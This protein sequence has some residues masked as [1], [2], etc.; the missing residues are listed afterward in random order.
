[1]PEDEVDSYYD[2]AVLR[3]PDKDEKGQELLPKLEKYLAE[4]GPAPKMTDK[5]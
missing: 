2:I 5:E 1:M 4:T 3:L